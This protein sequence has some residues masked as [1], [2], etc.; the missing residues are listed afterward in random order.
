LARLEA[1]TFL[2]SGYHALGTLG[3]GE[4]CIPLPAAVS[5]DKKGNCYRKARLEMEAKTM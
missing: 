1:Q 4:S 2:T 5:V 3:D